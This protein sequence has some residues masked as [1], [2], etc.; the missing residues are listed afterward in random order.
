[1]VVCV[2]EIKYSNT[3]HICQ[4]KLYFFVILQNRDKIVTFRVGFW[5]GEIKNSL[6]LIDELKQTSYF[7]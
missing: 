7:Y 6:T 1:M 5:S 4:V 2:D 3:V